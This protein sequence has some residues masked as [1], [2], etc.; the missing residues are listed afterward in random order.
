ME[1]ERNCGDGLCRGSPSSRTHHVPVPLP[2]SQPI[3]SA[4]QAEG[5]KREWPVWQ[6]EIPGPTRPNYE[7]FTGWPSTPDGGERDAAI[8]TGSFG[9]DVAGRVLF[10]RECGRPCLLMLPVRFSLVCRVS[11]F[12]PRRDRQQVPGIVG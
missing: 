9:D 8:A 6:L 5:L 11:G 3:Y 4:R 2:F 12:T 10:L 1:L 7:D